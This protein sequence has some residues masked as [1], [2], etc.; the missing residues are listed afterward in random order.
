MVRG[1]VGSGSIVNAL[2]GRRHRGPALERGRCCVERSEFTG[3]MRTSVT[4][5]RQR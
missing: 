5:G 1:N 2:D 4:H 3:C